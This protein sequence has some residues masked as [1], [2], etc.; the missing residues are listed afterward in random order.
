MRKICQI[1]G[2]GFVAASL[3]VTPVMAQSMDSG[4]MSEEEL[5]WAFEHQKTRNAEVP[6]EV[7]YKSDSFEG[8]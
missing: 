6:G 4:D 8:R 2:S 1:I 5:M 3:L 7:T